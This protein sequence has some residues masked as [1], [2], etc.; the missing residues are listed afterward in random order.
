MSKNAVYIKTFGCQMNAR[1]SEFVA[2]VLSDNGFS[3]VDSQ[4]KADVIIFNSC[5]VR[6]HAE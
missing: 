2:G 1:D 5:S 4:D 6:K 3:I